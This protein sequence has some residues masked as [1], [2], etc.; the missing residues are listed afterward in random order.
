M[1]DLI[2]IIGFLRRPARHKGRIVLTYLKLLA[3]RAFLSNRSSV[4]LFGQTVYFPHLPTLV[5][6]YEEI[7]LGQHYRFESA[8]KVPRIIDAGANIGLSTLYLKTLYPA[9]EIE[10]F[11]PDPASFAYLKRNVGEREGVTI[12]QAA[13]AE[14]EGELTLHGES[15]GASLRDRA[16]LTSVTS[17]VPAER[18]SGYLDR[19]VDFLK[20]DIE[21][22]EGPVLREAGRK[23]TNVDQIVLEFHQFAESA[24][25]S[26]V[27]D[28]FDAASHR[29]DISHWTHDP[30]N[31]AGYFCLIRTRHA[32]S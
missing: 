27:L 1:K 5:F 25:L 11:E 19:P 17:K 31:P 21:G 4:R 3:I 6:L 16:E 2:K 18:L 23:L 15:I 22:A 32:D 14:Q 13:L 28:I 26:E 30:S 12:H 20:M 8:V 9:A 29:Y 24:R 7:F 10:C